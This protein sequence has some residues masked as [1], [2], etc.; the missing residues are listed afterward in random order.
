VLYLHYG[1]PF[2]RHRDL[3][4]DATLGIRTKD[5][6]AGPVVTD[7]EPG[8][9]AERLGMRVDDLIVQLDKAPVFHGSDIVFFLRQRSAGDEVEIAYVR[10]AELRRVSGQLD[11]R[12]EKVFEHLA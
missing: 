11:K 6:T 2:A 7:L 1:I 5:S 9:L 8:Q 3:Q 4:S 12:D 10:G